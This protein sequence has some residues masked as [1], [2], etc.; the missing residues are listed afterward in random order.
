MVPEGFNG[1]GHGADIHV[2]ADGKFLY[3]STRSTLNEIAIYSIDQKTGMLNLIG[4]QPSFGRSSRTFEIDPSGKWLLSTGQASNEIIVFKRDK[5]T[6]KLSPIGEKL[7]I[8]KPSLV[9][10]VPID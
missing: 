3:A 9:K 2:S 4:R 6:G 7:Q 8:D 1:P 5:E 10:F